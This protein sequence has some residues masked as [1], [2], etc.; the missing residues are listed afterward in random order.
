[1]LKLSELLKNN[2]KLVVSYGRAASFSLAG[3]ANSTANT[4]HLS[5]MSVGHTPN[6]CGVSPGCTLAVHG[7]PDSLGLAGSFSLS[8]SL[9]I[10]N[11]GGELL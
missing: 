7:H 4:M 6:T 1:M 5:K 11:S 9:S 3:R 2:G 8:S 10:P